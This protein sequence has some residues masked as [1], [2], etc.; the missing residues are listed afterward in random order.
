[1]GEG[2][3][4]GKSLILLLLRSAGRAEGELKPQRWGDTRV[5]P[6][7][8]LILASNWR[9]SLPLI[10]EW[11]KPWSTSQRPYFGPG[12]G[13]GDVMDPVTAAG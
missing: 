13:L 11:R 5:D 12:E 2:V 3:D 6:R 4:K 10:P 9:D 7:D 1:M 8:L